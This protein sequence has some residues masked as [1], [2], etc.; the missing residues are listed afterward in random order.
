M[1]SENSE[2]LAAIKS[3]VDKSTKYQPNRP[4]VALTQAFLVSR[5][6]TEVDFWLPHQ[7]KNQPDF[8]KTMF[9]T[10]PNTA[11]WLIFG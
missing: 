8:V 6:P 10:H 11:P 5:P 7:P 3:L 9:F 4:A 1:P 2:R